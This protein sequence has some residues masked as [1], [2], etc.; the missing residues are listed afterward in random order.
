MKYQYYRPNILLVINPQGVI[1]QL[2]MPL[3]VFD[4]TIHAWVYV[5]EIQSND[6]DE[7][8]FVVNNQALLHSQF[9][10]TIYF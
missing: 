4:N 7:L 3:R 8:F 5:D 2:F 6:R 10:I 1:R 9:T